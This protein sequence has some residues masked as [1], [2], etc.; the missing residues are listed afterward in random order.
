[1]KRL[2]VYYNFTIAMTFVLLALFNARTGPELTASA[3]FSPLLIY[4]LLLVLP[5]KN[6]AIIEKE[7]APAQKTSDHEPAPAKKLTFDVDRRLFLKLIASGGISLFLFSLF[8][9]RADKTIFSQIQNVDATATKDT[10]ENYQITEI[11]DSIPTYHGYIKNDGAWFIR[12]EDDNGSFRY[13]KGSSD[14]TAN[15]ANRSSLQY[16]YFNNVF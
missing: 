10:I 8:N 1:M 9:Q 6:H 11:D 13:A 4:F 5:Q 14:F 7:L 15:W 16:D 12:R 3:L 2:L